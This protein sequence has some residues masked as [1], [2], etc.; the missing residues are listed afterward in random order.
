LLIHE[1]VRESQKTHVQMIFFSKSDRS[2]NS[3]IS[4]G[5][6]QSEGRRGVGRRNFQRRY[7]GSVN[8][9]AAF[10]PL[11]LAIVSAC[12]S[13]AGYHK[14]RSQA[15]ARTT[16]ACS[17]IA[18]FADDKTPSQIR[19]VSDGGSDTSGD[20]SAARPFRTV[21]RAAQQVAPG[22]AIF[23]HQGM[24]PGG[25]FLTDVHGTETQPIWIMG[26]P[27]E[28][29]PVIQGGNEALHLI[30]PRYV[31]LQH[32]EIAGTRDNGINIDDGGD[33]ANPEAARFLLFRDLDIHD[34]GTHPA[35]VA[36]C[37]KLAGVNDFFVLHSSFSRCGTGPE[38]GAVGVGA[39]GVHRGTVSFNRFFSNG[40]G[41]AQF[42][43][44]SDDVEIASNLFRDTGSRA[45]NMGGSTGAAF[46]RPPVSASA[47]HYEA[48]RIRASANIF[49]GSE[50]AASFTGCLDCAFTHNT[51]VNPSKWVIRILQETVT[52]AG[53]QFAPAANGLI[54]GNIFFFKRSD[55]NTGE[56]INVGVNTDSRSFL[57]THNFWFAHDEPA[58][59]NPRITRFEGTHARSWMATSPG[60][61]NPE[62]GD[63][64]LGA[65]SVPRGAGNVAFAPARDFA[66]R[67]YASPPSLGA[68][69]VAPR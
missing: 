52:S 43:G 32:L 64:H 59:S 30:R 4:G 35:G 66:G 28:A 47:R 13:P 56:D 9:I 58:Q 15:G 12:S 48:A 17:A 8:W 2:M 19:H 54:A 5:M 10:G 14:D 39:V 69:E 38:S 49:E 18:T 44:G 68:L 22:T 62:A 50:A 6:P 25:T 3:V 36:D 29:L 34:T 40:Y 61:T 21:A 23:L 63:F 42:K 60:F 31:V 27:D 51:V 57:L 7:A 55:L 20:G 41:G 53:Y 45:V 65:D 33:V 1:F 46:F 16:T 37:L 26:A 11:G 24:Y 67:C